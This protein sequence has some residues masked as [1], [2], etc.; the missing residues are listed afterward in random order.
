MT[1]SKLN[2]FIITLN[3]VACFILSF[4]VVHL[5]FQFATMGASAIFNIP[6]TLFLNKISY[7][8]SPESW[9][10]DSVKVIFS[11]GNVLLFILVI[12]FIVIYLK[13]LEFNGLLRLFVLWGFINSLSKLLGS[14]IIGAFSFEGFGIVMSYLYLT[15]TTKM[16]I[17]F[18]KKSIIILVV[19][20]K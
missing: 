9:T 1:P 12:T 5:F 19:S 16:I 14:M 3:S 15:D 7:N 17:L 11:A 2:Y 4:L 8:T 13:A 6:T 18:S 10:F 20:V